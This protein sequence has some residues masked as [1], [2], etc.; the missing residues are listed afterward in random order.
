MILNILGNK[1]NPSTPRHQCRGL[2]RVDPERRVPHRPE[3]RGLAPP[4]GPILFGLLSE[5]GGAMGIY[6]RG[7]S[8]PDFRIRMTQEY[9]AFKNFQTSARRSFLFPFCFFIFCIALLNFSGFCAGVANAGSS[10]LAFQDEVKRI[11]KTMAG[12][13]M[14]PL[15]KRDNNAIQAILDKVILDA[16]K[17]GKP[18][19]FGIGILDMEGLAVAG[20]YIV[21]TFKMDDFSKY[22]Y[23]TKAFKQKKIVQD[24]LYF[25]G[26]SQFLIICV[27][28]VRQKEVVGA[29]VFG[30]DPS[31]IEKNYGLTTE[32]F[33]ALDFNK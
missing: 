3:G 29:L 15:S 30:F 11:I 1:V 19:R 18:V 31:Q 26:G 32:Q 21:G 13:M 17:E 22:N 25:Q 7:V 24:R 9:L 5:K 4:N 6:K 27:P 16:E 12:P 8:G 23:V 33:M 14:G 10:T 20:R 2:L 28:L